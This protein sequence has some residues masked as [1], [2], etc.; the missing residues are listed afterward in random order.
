MKQMLYLHIVVNIE[1][2]AVLWL[3]WFVFHLAFSNP[4]K[5]FS[6][7][8]NLVQNCAA[9]RE[10]IATLEQDKFLASGLWKQALIGFLSPRFWHTRQYCDSHCLLK[11]APSASQSK[12][13][14]ERMYHHVIVD[15]DARFENPP[16]GFLVC[17]FF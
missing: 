12:C 13:F 11:K 8:G 1:Q 16:V 2:W 5:N 9:D 10:C 3:Q 7:R 15:K 6:D 17:C 14:E 4:K